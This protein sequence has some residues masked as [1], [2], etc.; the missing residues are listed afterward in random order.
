M[1]IKAFCECKEYRNM[2]FAY[3]VECKHFVG[4]LR[5]V[6]GFLGGL[7]FCSVFF[8]FFFFEGCGSVF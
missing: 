7:L 5:V 6:W 2:V 1:S 3:R 8:L 4:L